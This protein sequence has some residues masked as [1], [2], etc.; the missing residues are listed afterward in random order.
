MR[1]SDE[2][3]GPI[4][5]TYATSPNFGHGPIPLYT[6]SRLKGKFKKEAFTW[7]Q[8]PL[9]TESWQEIYERLERRDKEIQHRILAL[10]GSQRYLKTL[11]GAGASEAQVLR[12]LCFAVSKEKGF[13]RQPMRRKKRELESIA[14][15]LE[16]VANHAQRV[17]LDPLSNGTLWLA[18][19]CIGKWDDVKPASERSPAW[20]FGFMRLYAKNCRDKARAFGDLLRK[21]PPRQNRQMIDCLILEVWLRTRKYH[22]KEIAFLLTNAY[23]AV[24]RKREVTEDQIKKHR[25]RYVMPRIEAYLISH[26][27][28]PSSGTRDN[29]NP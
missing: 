12:L 8:T 14:D 6:N 20:L 16:T 7:D 13:W 3:R 10:P 19:L 17:S 22:D 11:V 5:K 29:Q 26:P 18:M 9:M 21:Y 15:Q 4:R 1:Q 23:E 27:V 25:Q 28:L 24:G 2:G